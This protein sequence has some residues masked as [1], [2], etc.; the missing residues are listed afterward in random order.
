MQHWLRTPVIDPCCSSVCQPS[1]RDYTRQPLFAHQS[2]IREERGSGLAAESWDEAR[3]ETSFGFWLPNVA[4][5]WDSTSRKNRGTTW[6]AH[7]SR[8][9]LWPARLS[10]PSSLDRPAS[11]RHASDHKHP[12]AADRVTVIMTLSPSP[13]SLKF[14]ARTRVRSWCN[15]Y[16]LQNP[17]P[18]SQKKKK[19]KLKVHHCV[20]TTWPN[21]RQKIDVNRKRKWTM[22]R[23][24]LTFPR[25]YT[26]RRSHRANHIT[27]CRVLSS[28]T[29]PRF[30]VFPSGKKLCIVQ[31]EF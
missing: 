6:E 18:S 14:V 24:L 8:P 21:K 4:L 13:S 1:A 15:C 25:I 12:Q 31:H 7:G 27:V 20:S 11:H 19:T 30:Y 28:K 23:S 16:I 17:L 10:R 26:K 5:S 22:N 3:P 29:Y 2:T 9:L